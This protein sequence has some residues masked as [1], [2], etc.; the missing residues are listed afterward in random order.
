MRLKQIC[1]LWLLLIL[2]SPGHGQQ[3][4]E[5]WVELGVALVM[6]GRYTE[7]MQYFDE[8]I[9]IN[10][11]Y[12][13]AWKC[14]GD[15][16]YDQGKFEDAASATRVE[17]G[18]ITHRR[19]NFADAI[20]AYNEAIRLD[21]E[22]AA[23]WK[24]KGDALDAIGRTSEA[25]QAYNE[26]I[27]LDMNLSWAWYKKGNILYY[28]GNNDEA[29]RAYEESVRLDSN[30]A[31]AWNGKGNVLKNQGRHVA[32]LVAYNEAINQYPNYVD[33]WFGKSFTL[34]ALGRTDEAREAWS[35]AYVLREGVNTF[36]KYLG[37]EDWRKRRLAAETLG[38]I[39]NQKAIG[40]LRNLVQNDEYEE[41][42][43]ASAQ[44]LE[45]IKER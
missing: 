41:V 17:N 37:D 19:G 13:P 33:A 2:V 26:A 39:G 20:Q 10:P 11:E 9:R 31:P 34:E 5:E 30:F 6:Q 1:V 36:I 14:K 4:A 23:A 21:P 8:A 45:K 29:L 24:C 3:A 28:Q 42:R 22:Y 38:D 25:M 12:A 27:R 16:L 15:A 32:A 18:K 44:A 35:V 43:M 40:P 7:A